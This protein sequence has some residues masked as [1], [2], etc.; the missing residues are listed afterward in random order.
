MYSRMR[1][2]GIEVRNKKRTTKITRKR[3]LS[4]EEKNEVEGPI[5]GSKKRDEA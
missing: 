5:M 3:R 1:D 2:M 4:E